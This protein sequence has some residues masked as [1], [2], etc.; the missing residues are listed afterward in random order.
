MSRLYSITKTFVP[1]R[2]AGAELEL[3]IATP[4]GAGRFPA[5]VFNHGSTGRG[6]NEAVFRRTISPAVIAGYFAQRGWITIF[7]QRRG[8][9]KSGGV[10]G[11][12]LTPEGG[13]SCHTAIALAGFERAV[14][15]IDDVMDSLPALAGV[16]M[17]RLAIG[18]VS[19]GGILAIAFAG[20]RPGLFKAAVNFNGGWLGQAC[21]GY[22]TLNP[23]LFRRGATAGVSTLWLHGSNDPYY[24]IAH[25]VKNHAQF[26]EAGGL[27]QFVDLRA[28]H[29]LMFKPA[30]WA[31]HMDA[32]LDAQI[33]S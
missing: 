17:I 5:M 10:Y 30:L 14:E 6:L 29:G 26:L 24:S 20:M 1:S 12:G 18:G 4:P 22:E 21:P 32:Y 2:E 3:V 33:P 15:D 7:P 23:H 16:D 19:R 31:A 27:G 11:E 8:R 25:C 13:Y 9:G 28:G